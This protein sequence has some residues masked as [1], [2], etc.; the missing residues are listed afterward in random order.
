MTF[1]VAAGYAQDSTMPVGEVYTLQQCIAIG[2]KN[3]TTVKTSQFTME[4]DKAVYQQ[5]VGNMLPYA[6]ASIYHQAYNGRSI[7]PYTNTYIDQG[8]TTANYQLQASI[9][10]WNGS[11]IQRFMRQTREAYRAGELDLQQSKDNAAIQI[12]LDYLSV[13]SDQ[14]LLNAAKVQAAATAEQVRVYKERSD[15]GTIGPGDYYTLKGQ[16]GQNQVAVTTARN[17]LEIAKLTLSKDMN[18]NYSSTMTLTPIGDTT[19]LEPYGSSVEEIYATSLHALPMVRSAD[20]KEQSAVNGIKAARGNLLPTLYLTGGTQT[21]F[22]N[23]ATT[24][25]FQN[26]TQVN[27][28]QYVTVGGTQYSVFS[29]QNNYQTKNL[30]YGNQIGNNIAYYVG[31]QLS[32]PILNGL[33]ARTKLRQAKIAEET[34]AF[35]RSTTH[36]QLRQAVETDYVNMTA[37]FE[38]YKT[39][40]QQV[41]DYTQSY[42][43][44][45]AKLDAGTISAYEFVIAKNNLDGANLNLIG[46]KYNYILQTKILDYYLGRISF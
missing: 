30:S 31:V 11:S 41:D 7:N 12:I 38:T 34:A 21:N 9:V 8:Q 35:N 26:T 22:S 18:V 10:V 5:S 39:L 28:E 27:T 4:S 2:I 16:L 13:L 17:T 33:Q 14:E 43:A 46:A 32:I 40:H 23:L 44:A 25:I 42:S 1:L 37:A 45:N 29:P 20:L 19:I 24:Q 36:I 3:N 6:S 15:A